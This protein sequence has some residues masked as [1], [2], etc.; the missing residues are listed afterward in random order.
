VLHSASADSSSS[1]SSSS[2]SIPSLCVKLCVG[3]MLFAGGVWALGAGSEA[4][5]FGTGAADAGVGFSGAGFGS[6]LGAGNFGSDGKRRSCEENEI[7]KVN[8]S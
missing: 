2:I 5:T 6:D 4:S 3:S 8:D 1:P 7:I